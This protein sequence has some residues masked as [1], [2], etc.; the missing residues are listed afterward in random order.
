MIK[1][2]AVICLAGSCHEYTVATSE[3]DASLN[4]I[5]CQMGEPRIVEWIR[6][7]HPGATLARWKCQIGRDRK[8]I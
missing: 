3:T 1:L 8:E 6:V 5:G 7:E 2:F 4:M